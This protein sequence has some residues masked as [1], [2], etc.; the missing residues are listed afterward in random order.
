MLAFTFRRW[1][2]AVLVL[3]A[4]AAASAQDVASSIDQLRVLVRPGE[5]V[6]LTDATGRERTVR[7]DRISASSLSVTR[8]CVTGWPPSR[9]TSSNSSPTRTLRCASGSPNRAVS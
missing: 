2:I 8:A 7:I 4:P 6:R 1:A 3:G 5:T 9:P